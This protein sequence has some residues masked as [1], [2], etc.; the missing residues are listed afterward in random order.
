VQRAKSPAIVHQ[1][2]RNAD[3]VFLRGADGRRRM[4]YLGVHGSEDARKRYHE[5]LAAHLDGVDPEPRRPAL[6]SSQP[7]SSWPTVEQLCGE[8][9]VWA[10]REFLDASTG[11]VSREV[12]NFDHAIDHLRDQHRDVP[13]DRFTIRDLQQIRQAMVD[14][15]RL[16]RNVINARVRRIKAVFRWG[17]EQG[18]VPGDVWHQLS[19][20]RGLR[21][22]RGGARETKPVE[23]VTWKQ[24]EELQ[25]HLP[26]CVYGALLLQWWSGMRPDEVLQ[27]TR[28]QLDM[29]GKVW[30][31]RPLR[32]KG[33]WRGRERV[34]QLGP[35]AQ[36]ALRPMLKLEPDAAIISPQDAWAW[37]KAEKRRLRKTPMTPSQRARNAARAR[38]AK[39]KLEFF[40][41]PTYRR[42]IA[43]ACGKAGMKPWGPHRLR[44]A[45]GTRL[46]Q[47]EGIEAA[48]VALGHVDDRVT[49]RY[50]HSADSAAAATVAARHG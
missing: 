19:A 34:V 32:H 18:Y 47:Q 35:K 37:F 49:R 27:L 41:V 29:S 30:L 8:F 33:R 12:V 23:P 21:E 28:R 45:C 26:P 43:R 2:S 50:A 24:V 42:L 6:H 38:R 44:H 22:G 16:C 7:P 48:R 36:E 46:A 20:L 10:E 1:K 39:P 31:F 14:G 15:G 9:T 5:V 3:V 25:R 11:K 17:V 4:I 40:D 13:V